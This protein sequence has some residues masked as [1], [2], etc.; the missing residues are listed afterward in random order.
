MQHVRQVFDG[1]SAFR[2]VV[3]GLIP[4]QSDMMKHDRTKL[5]SR[6]LKAGGRFERVW[7]YFIPRR[8]KN[9]IFLTTNVYRGE[10]I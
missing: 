10:I 1:E 2:I 5:E 7:S 4:V 8:K 9:R 6:G 3:S